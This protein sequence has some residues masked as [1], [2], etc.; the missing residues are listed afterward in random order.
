MARLF[1]LV[2]ILAAMAPAQGGLRIRVKW[3]GA[4]PKPKPLVFPASTRR[5][6]PGD[7]AYCGKCI[8]TGELVDETLVVDPTS[9]G[10]RDIAITLSGP[11]SPADQ[12]PRPAV[13]DNKSCRFQPRV[14]FAPVG[15]TVKVKNSDAVT[16]NARIVGRGRRQFWNGIIPAQKA[17][18]TPKIAVAGVLHVV[19]DVHPWM[20]AWLIGTR[21]HWVGVT[22]TTGEVV[23]AAIPTD[24]PVT[25]H[26]WHPHLGRCRVQVVLKDGEEVLRT[27][28]QKDFRKR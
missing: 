6:S 13:V 5:L 3:D 22:Q 8:T 26:L 20:E 21:S 9:R 14:Q 1:P 19:C 16:H 17:I 4:V 2:L 15:K 25:V 28:T 24:E 7:A 18:E 11:K 23:L 12:L 27:L 10:I